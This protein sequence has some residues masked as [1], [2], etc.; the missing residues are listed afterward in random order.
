VIGL[1]P[2]EVPTLDA[3][4]LL[5][6]TGKSRLFA[7]RRNKPAMEMHTFLKS[8]V[9]RV[10]GVDFEIA[11]RRPGDPAKIVAASDRVRMMLGWNPHYDDLATIIAHALAWEQTLRKARAG[12]PVI[13]R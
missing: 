10:S 11:P 5:R 13:G 7:A 9:K 2:S 8:E 12:T 6:R 4:R 1:D 3:I